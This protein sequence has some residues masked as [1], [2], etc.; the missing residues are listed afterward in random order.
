MNK[1]LLILL[2]LASTQA[3]AALKVFACEPEWAALTQELAGDK[4]DIYIATT[5]MQDPHFV[6]ARPSLIARAHRAQLVVCT[7]AGLEVGWLPLV[8]RESSN[9]AIAPGQDGNF[10]A[11]RYVT[12]LEKPQRLSRSE[13]DVHPDGNPHIQLDA[14]NFLPIAQALAQR[15][16]MLDPDN[17]AFYNQRL[18]DFTTRWQAAIAR[19]EKQAAPLKGQAII[20][21]HKAFSYLN[22]W[23][24]LNEV[25]E[26]EPKPGM[27]PSVAHMSDVLA[28]LRHHPAKMV[29]RAS[30]QQARPSEWMAEHAHIQAVALPFSIGG[31]DRAKDLFGLFDDIVAQLLAGLK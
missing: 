5:A 18:Q 28:T 15:L 19:W 25:A 31:S 26:L 22:H 1:F 7:G 8:L 29:V 11:S 21:H 24:G 30:Y 3:Q 23:L 2:L 12:M 16:G 17:A 4:A 6:Q 13:G 20:V 14:R 9:P 27:E 10:V